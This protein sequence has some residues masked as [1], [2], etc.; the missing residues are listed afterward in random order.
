MVSFNRTLTQHL[1]EGLNPLTSTI[2]QVNVGLLCNL[3]CRHCHVEASPK[4]DEIM[5]RE[6]ME[7]ILK[8]VT[9]LKPEIADIT[10]GAPEMNPHLKWFCS[11]LQAAGI[12]VQV[13][14]NLT[15]LAQSEYKDFI[16]YYQDNEIRLVAS[17]PC[18]TSENVKKQRGNQVFEQSIEVLQKL[19]DAG[20]GRDPKLNLDLVFNPGGPALP[21]DQ[22]SLEA[23]YK[24]VL[25]KDFD[26]DFNSL[27]T[28]T[29]IMIGRFKTDLERSGRADE[30]SELL[31]R[32][33]NADTLNGLMCRN[34]IN[35]GWDGTIYDC[36]FNFALQLPVENSTAQNIADYDHTTYMKRNI[37]TADHCYACTA[38]CG[39]S[40]SGSIA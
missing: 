14:T 9:D 20:Y 21:G 23:D 13:R 33:F 4:R 30:Y 25:K 22:Q 26:I 32:S 37:V 35:I 17:L 28:I 19:N 7:H 10:G 36:D 18:Y 38:G 6:T 27:L 24:R 34:Q 31:F 40:C 8:A 39:S 2:L 15:I 29:N 12:T 3:A 5:N 1:L 11:Q 16:Q